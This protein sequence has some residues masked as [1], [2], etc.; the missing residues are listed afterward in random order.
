MLLI[1]SKA[2]LCV[3]IKYKRKHQTQKECGKTIILLLLC[4]VCVYNT[5]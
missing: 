4:G 3:F 1:D 5:N 2:N